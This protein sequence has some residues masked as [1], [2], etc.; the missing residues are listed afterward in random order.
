MLR[1]IHETE[2]PGDRLQLVQEMQVTKMGKEQ[3][4]EVGPISQWDELM[5]QSWGNSWEFD[6]V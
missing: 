6:G 1:E 5:N 3:L 2:Q 4:K